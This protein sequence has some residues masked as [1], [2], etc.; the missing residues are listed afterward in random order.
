MSVDVSNLGKGNVENGRL[1]CNKTIFYIFGYSE[2]L[3]IKMWNYKFLNFVPTNHLNSEK[4]T[5]HFFSFFL[6][7]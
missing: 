4:Y 3:D 7:R 2:V 5:L 1:C 6:T